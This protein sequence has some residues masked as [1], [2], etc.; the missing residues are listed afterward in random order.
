MHRPRHSANGRHK[1]QKSQELANPLQCER[2]TEI[3]RL[4]GVLPLLYTRLLAHCLTT[5]RLNTEYN[6]LALGRTTANR[7]RNTIRQN[8][9]QTSTPTAR[10]HQ[11][12]HCTNRR[13]SLWHGSHTL[14]RGRS[15]ST[16]THKETQTTPGSVLLGHIHSHKKGL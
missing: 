6:P 5:T 8:V 10:L 11:T 7:I 15:Q 3:P 16:K 9:Q 13:I 12:F 14:A 4:H 1:N 2:S